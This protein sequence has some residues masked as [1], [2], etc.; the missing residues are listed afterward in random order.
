MMKVLQICLRVPYPPKDGGAVAMNNITNGLIEN[1]VDVK[2]LA[3]NTPKHYVNIQTLPGDYVKKTKFEALD[4]DT[5]IKV[6][7]AIKNIVGKDSFNVSRFYSM[8]FEQKLVDILKKEEFD[9]IQLESLFTTPYIDAIK[10]YSKARVVLRSHNVEYKIWETL[11]ANSGNPLKKAYLKFLTGR[12][13]QYEHAV[14]KKCDALVNITALDSDHFRV[15]GYNKQI[16]TI[17]FGIDTQRYDVLRKKEAQPSLFHLGALDWMP[18]QQGLLWFL[19]NC[20]LKLLDS[21]PSLKFH[22]AGRNI[23]QWFRDLKYPNV[24]IE[25]EVEDAVTFMNQHSVMVVPLFSGSGMRT[26]IIEGMAL[27]K[28]IVSTTVGVSGIEATHAKEILIADTPGHFVK[29]IDDC[30]NDSAYAERISSNC[31]ELVKKNY[32]NRVLSSKLVEFYKQ[33][34]GK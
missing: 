23:P 10:K 14:I 22:V 13:R 12:L 21:H 15:N 30:L 1:G 7:D 27:G 4:V 33:L 28:V 20:W 8:A 18:N 26:K 29:S 25:G 2:V 9:V 5:R 3:I 34:T 19:E 24:V 6:S 32:D 16:L 17:P 11:A 31:I